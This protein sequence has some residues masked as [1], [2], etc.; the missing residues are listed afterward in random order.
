LRRKRDVIKDWNIQHLVETGSIRP[1]SVIRE[2]MQDY[3]ASLTTTA[4]PM[5]GGT[6]ILDTDFVVPYFG[7]CTYNSS[8]IVTDQ[9]KIYG[10]YQ[11]TI[12]VENPVSNITVGNNVWLKHGE[13]CN[14][15][16]KFYGTS[17]FRYCFKQNHNS[18]STIRNSDD[19][20]DECEDF[21][22]RETNENEVK[23][24]R[25]LPKTS[26]TYTIAFYVKNEVSFIKTP[27]GIQFYEGE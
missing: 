3:L 1:E 26:N 18:S 9:K 7:I 24:T 21:E 25:F 14:L 15:T 13:M 8:K 6:K 22:W 20:D 2:D 10:Y 5:D 17:P 11:R 16:L 4:N 19:H 27:I 12:Q 23:F